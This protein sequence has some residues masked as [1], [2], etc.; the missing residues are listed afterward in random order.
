[1]KRL[2]KHLTTVF[3]V[4]IFFAICHIL[5]FLVVDF[6]NKPEFEEYKS[7]E[8][9]QKI[10]FIIPTY[11]RRKNGH[12][13]LIKTFESIYNIFSK[14][15]LN[16]HVYAFEKKGQA[17]S[18]FQHSRF[19]YETF[20]HYK[21]PTKLKVY[22]KRDHKLL[23]QNLD[24]ISMMVA[25]RK[26]CEK[27]D[28]FIYLEDDFTFCPNSLPHI[29]A[30]YNYVKSNPDI[31]GIKFS[32]G[33]NGNILRCSNI[34]RIVLK[35]VEKCFV[36]DQHP[37]V[38][39]WSLGDYWN[40]FFGEGNLHVYRYNLMEHIGVESTLD[41]DGNDKDDH[42]LGS[43][44]CFYRMV[45]PSLYHLEIFDIWNCQNSMVSPCKNETFISDYFNFIPSPSEN[46][47]ES[48]LS[49]QLFKSISNSIGMKLYKVKQQMSC[50]IYCQ[51]KN[52]MCDNDSF[53][54]INNCEILKNNFGCT[55]CHSSE[56]NVSPLI[57]N[58]KCFVK[59]NKNF[60]C[61]HISKV[62]NR[63]CPCIPIRENVKNDQKSDRKFN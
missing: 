42:R 47:F 33:L 35:A 9:S 57:F 18:P 38:I 19:H 21:I 29:L 28:I 49:N 37:K 56:N 52:L 39:D 60:D 59:R 2:K 62:G 27:N 26:M 12:G 7:F 58:N 55:S 34:E 50:D 13:Y 40:Q 51:K 61:S 45:H 48:P 30:A 54:F 6:K 15:S 16:F 31:F 25:Y 36:K 43:A 3:F 24:W 1:M 63:V 8:N 53:Q 41:N 17:K 5:W 44:K 46:S 14:Y 4:L 20:D 11:Y 23:K 32:F 10:N 22:S